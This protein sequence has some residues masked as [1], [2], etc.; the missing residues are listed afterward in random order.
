MASCIIRCGASRLESLTRPR[1]FLAGMIGMVVGGGGAHV[2]PSRALVTA[3]NV[4]E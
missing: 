3:Q 2:C 4:F 1:P